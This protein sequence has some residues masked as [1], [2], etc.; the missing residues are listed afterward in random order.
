MTTPPQPPNEPRLGRTLREDIGRR[1]LWQNVRRDFRELREFYLDEEKKA[2]LKGMHPV[3]RFLYTTGWLLKS[4]F[5]RLTPARRLLLLLGLI[6]VVLGPGLRYTS[7]HGEGVSVQVNNLH[8]VGGFLLLFVL[9]L[10]LKDK[11]LARDE[12]E[13]GRRVQRALM[14]ERQPDVPGYSIWLF[15]R[16]ANEVG[17]DL[18]DFLQLSNDRIGLMMG[19]VAGKGLQAALLTAKLQAT[20]RALAPDYTSPGELARKINAIFHRDSLPNI[21]ASLLYFDV[22]PSTGTMRLVNA[23]HPPPLLVSATGTKELSKGEPALGLLA[24]YSYAEHEFTLSTNELLFAYSDGLTESRA[25]SGEFLG[26][27]RIIAYLQS[28]QGEP[29]E[30]LGASLLRQIDAFLGQSGMTDDLSLLIAK[31][32]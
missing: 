22:I 12:L 26:L 11:L 17:G 28:H 30:A 29:A 2:M 20:L 27:D 6:L 7:G 21:F 32:I 10:E 18:V 8:L 9:M 4:M 31:R 3:R 25:E 15:T 19:D 1:D 14:P 5:L 16:P 24:D 23:G 13:A